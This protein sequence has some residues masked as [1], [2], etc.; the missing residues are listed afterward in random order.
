MGGSKSPSSSSST[1]KIDPWLK[2]QIEG[3]LDT[4]QNLPAYQQIPTSQAFAPVTGQMRQSLGQMRQLGGQGVGLLNQGANTMRR[5]AGQ[6][7]QQVNPSGA[8]SADQISAGQADL[9]PF[10]NPYQ[11]QVVDQTMQD[12]NRARQ[13]SIVG[14]EDAAL[15]AGAFGGSRHGIADSE[16]NR[17]FAEQAARTAGQLNAQGFNTALGAAQQQQGM[18]MGAQQANQQANL[19]A[20]QFNV[21]TDLAAQQANQSAGLD[22]GRLNLLAGQGLLGQGMQQFG[23]GQQAAQFG[24]DRQ[25][26]MRDFQVQQNQQAQ[27]DPRLLAQMES[28][29]I[30]GIPFM[31]STTQTQPGGSRLGGGLPQ[32]LQWGLSSV[33]HG[34]LPSVGVSASW[35]ACSVKRNRLWPSQAQKRY[36]RFSV[37]CPLHRQGHS[38]PPPR[39]ARP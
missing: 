37:V 23:L 24:Q 31:G 17:A 6:D 12:L 30:Q 34:V 16:T 36:A 27:M 28:S 21:G 11:Q 1:Q 13:M 39:K 14:G 9:S 22:A 35:A 29:A 10:Q 19:G 15:G 7:A 4:I 25:Q 32:A 8:I 20:Q 38:I 2:G 3:N 18:E 26:A 5:V 33:G